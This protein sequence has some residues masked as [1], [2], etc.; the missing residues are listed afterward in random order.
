MHYIFDNCDT[1][2]LAKE[3]ETP[4]YVMSETHIVE[5]CAEIRRDF[6][7]KY[8]NTK[9]LFAS[10]AFQTLEMCRIIQR[11]G[12]GMDVVS[13]GEIYTAI[14][15]GAKAENLMFHGNNKSQDEMDLALKE[16]VGTFVSDSLS[17]LELLNERAGLQGKKASVLLR[18]TP[19]VDSHTHQY[20]ST[21]HLDS[22]FGF[23]PNKVIEPGFLTGILE[24]F[25]NLDL[26]G[27]HIHVGSQLMDNRSHVLATEIILNI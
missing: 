11:E 27:F 2:E 4:L 14:K 18:V 25:E 21:G 13:G 24:N 12:L 23:S 15:A 9:A 10:K 22:K 7:E 17:E 3:Y 5:R 16:G 19:G 20:I 8:P 1:V 26:K 6:L